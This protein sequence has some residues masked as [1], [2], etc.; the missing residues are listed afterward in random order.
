MKNNCNHKWRIPLHYNAKS[1]FNPTE[2]IKCGKQIENI[3]DYLNNTNQEKYFN[4]WL[5]KIKIQQ[6]YY[7]ILKNKKLNEDDLRIMFNRG[8]TPIDALNA[9][10]TQT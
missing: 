5:G 4:E 9:L 6:R 8:I 7:P 1:N 10:I 2:C 3:N